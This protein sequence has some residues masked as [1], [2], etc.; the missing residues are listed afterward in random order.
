[1]CHVVADLDASVALFAGLLAGETTDEGT[2]GGMRWVDLRWAGPLGLRLV[3]AEQPGG[4][5]PVAD[6][7]DGLPGRVHHIAF[8]TEEPD[9]VP[10]TRPAPPGIATLGSGSDH[11]LIPADENCGLAVVLSGFGGTSGTHADGPVV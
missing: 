5:G 4:P 8:E 3:G 6:W 9:A 7:L 2:E 1:V 11:L 10:G